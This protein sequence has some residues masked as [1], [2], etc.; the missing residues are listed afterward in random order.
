[1]KERDVTSE[2]TT[3]GVLD[4]ATLMNI[5]SPQGGSKRGAA[6]AAI[7]P[8]RQQ[9]LD[10]FEFSLGSKQ[11]MQGALNELSADEIDAMFKVMDRGDGVDVR[12]GR[13]KM[14]FDIMTS[15]RAAERASLAGVA[16]LKPA[17]RFFDYGA[18]VG[19]PNRE[20][21]RAI[22]RNWPTDL[23]MLRGQLPETVKAAE[24]QSGQESVGTLW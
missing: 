12:S 20:M 1:M 8:R 6:V 9:T 4:A 24:A 19:G 21:V 17:A 13:N 22:A 5:I 10:D 16:A 15:K 3:G 7:A 14:A 11:T 23:S 18:L 2:A